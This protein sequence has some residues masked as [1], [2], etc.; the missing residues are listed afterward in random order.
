MRK[1]IARKFLPA[2]SRKAFEK[3]LPWKRSPNF[4]SERN[5]R[6][7]SKFYSFAGTETATEKQSI[8][9]P[10]LSN[11]YLGYIS[12]YCLPFQYLCSLKNTCVILYIHNTSKYYSIY[13]HKKISQSL[14]FRNLQRE[15]NRVYFHLANFP[16]PMDDNKKY[17]FK[18]N[19][20]N[21]SFAI[22]TT[23]FNV[24][25]IPKSGVFFAVSLFIC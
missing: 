7:S 22:I 24:L 10:L 3:L 19:F 1:L 9:T 16:F 25:R 15:L 14:W 6:Q 20:G 21:W 8:Y 2:R 13:L 23:H 4:R 18:L 11:V 17:S 12:K 5:W